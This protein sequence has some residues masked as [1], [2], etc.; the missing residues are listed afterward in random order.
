MFFEAVSVNVFDST[1][2]LTLDYQSTNPYL[3]ESAFRFPLFWR[4]F[5]QLGSNLIK[6]WAKCYL[7]WQIN[8]I[9]VLNCRVCLEWPLR[10]STCVALCGIVWPWVVLH[11]LFMALYGL[12]WQNIVFSRVHRSKFI[13]SCYPLIY[14]QS[15]ESPP[16]PL[17]RCMQL[18]ILR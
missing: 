15:R 12:L 16:L 13:W 1:A 6:Q 14:F 10:Q 17:L 18:S 9:M 5:F 8:E 4:I 3:S 7:L 11:G 2:L